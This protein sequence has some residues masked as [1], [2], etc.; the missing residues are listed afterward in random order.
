MRDESP[1]ISCPAIHVPQIEPCPSA[2]L[3]PEGLAAIVGALRMHPCLTELSLGTTPSTADV[4]GSS[5]WIDSIWF[6]PL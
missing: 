4:Y 5:V 2:E 3:G 6:C 1:L